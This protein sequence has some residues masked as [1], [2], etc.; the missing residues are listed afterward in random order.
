MSRHVRTGIVAWASLILALFLMGCGSDG[1]ERGVVTGKITLNGEPLEGADVEFQ[2]EEGSPSYGMTDGKGRYDLMYT[3][4]KRG[5]MIGE[6]TVRI[7]T[8]TTDTDA[9]GNEVAVPQRVPPKYNA[10]SELTRE[11]KPGRNKFNF[12]L[13]NP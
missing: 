4:D 3:R 5:A 6:H 13:S 10:Q 12:E 2:P 1:P 7:T 11:V 9:R 8:S